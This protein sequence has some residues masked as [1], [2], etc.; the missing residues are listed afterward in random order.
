MIEHF[1]LLHFTTECTV[2]VLDTEMRSYEGHLMHSKSLFVSNNQVWL[3]FTVCSSSLGRTRGMCVIPPI[4]HA[5]RTHGSLSNPSSSLLPLS[6]SSFSYLTQY[7]SAIQYCCLVPNS[8]LC[9]TSSYLK[10]Q[11]SP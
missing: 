5:P 1:N 9:Y 4:S 10:I 3:Y 7:P 2:E 8:N 11:T 6:S